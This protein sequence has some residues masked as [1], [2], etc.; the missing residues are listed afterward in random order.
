M[1]QS[2]RVGERPHGSSSPPALLPAQT[3]F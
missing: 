1:F 2:Q 3:D